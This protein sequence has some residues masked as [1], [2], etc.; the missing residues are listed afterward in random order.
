MHQPQ[1]AVV[2]N[3]LNAQVQQA[4]EQ[5]CTRY[6]FSKQ[7]PPLDIVLH[8]TST[9]IFPEAEGQPSDIEALPEG[10]QH[11]VV[12]VKRDDRHAVHYAKANSKEG[13]MKRLEVGTA[14]RWV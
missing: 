13:G 5:K 9:V 8:E 7:G 6:W 4:T 1:S 10:E 2:K 12:E 11:G 14:E 3:R